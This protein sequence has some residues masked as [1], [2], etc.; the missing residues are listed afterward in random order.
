MGTRAKPEKGFER[1][2]Q[3]GV[4]LLAVTM[5]IAVCLVMTQEFMTNTTTDFFAAANA[6]D[7][8]RSHFLARSAMNLGNLVIRLQTDILD[9]Y[10]K[11]I[12]DV[13]VADYVGFIMSPFA[14]S[15]EEVAAVGEAFGGVS[16]D[17]AKG[18]GLPDDSTFDLD[19]VTD[20]DKINV[21][22]ANG[23][24]DAKKVL[25]SR[26]D[27]LWY[28]PAFNPVFERPDATGWIRDREMQTLAIIDYIDRDHSKFGVPG[29][30]E[31]YG[32]ETLHD[33]YI[34]KDNYLDSVGELRQ[35]RGVDDRF[36]TLFGKVFTIYGSCKI[37]LGAVRDPMMIASI[38]LLT[39]KEDE[40]VL[41]DGLKLWALARRIAEAKDFGIYFDDTQ[42]FIDYVADPDAQLAELLGGGGAAGLT[43]APAAGS[44][45]PVEG[46]KLDKGKLD[47][48]A[49]IGARRTYRVIATATAGASAFRP[50]VSRRI[51]AVWDTTTTPQNA[52]P[53]Q[54]GKGAWVLWREE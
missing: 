14:G 10:R 32:Y 39:A 16:L 7:N 17:G 19:I 4:A 36:W 40:A 52:R 3:K 27:S 37:N 20:D 48:I 13:Q 49:E 21:N 11:Q 43:P 22:C 5:A 25:K 31:D 53:T 38:I 42:A 2:P 30:P 8:V 12:G 6:R 46:A 15:K 33:R 34:S 35:V 45:Q 23:N 54:T 1:D 47:Q 28:L 50:G 29:A 9:R 41:N 18:L 26:L 51:T 44:V 24:D